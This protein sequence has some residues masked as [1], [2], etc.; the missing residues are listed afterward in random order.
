VDRT[1]TSLLCIILV[2][3]QFRTKQGQVG[4]I[5]RVVRV[6]ISGT[7][8][9]AV[10]LTA[11]AVATRNAALAIT[12]AT[13]AGTSTAT[14]AIAAPPMATVTWARR[15]AGTVAMTDLRLTGAVGMRTTEWAAGEGTLVVSETGG[16][17]YIRYPGRRQWFSESL[18]FVADL[19]QLYLCGNRFASLTDPSGTVRTQ[20]RRRGPPMDNMGGPP[21]MAGYGGGGGGGGGHYRDRSRSRSRERGPP[22][23]HPGDRGDRYF[24]GGPGGPPGGP[25]PMYPPR[26]GYERGMGPPPYER[27]PPERGPPQS[28]G[29]RGGYE[30]GPG[31]GG[32]GGGYDMGR[33]MR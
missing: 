8:T 33:P 2:N 17:S 18:T 23:G 4:W 26:G 11:P 22:M 9:I 31:R 16:N 20:L 28:G 13:A 24:R 21:P 1:E 5:T 10:P 12:R 32:G 29:Y 30:G 19:W 7:T 27:G 3:L 25:G 6:A 14:L 15:W